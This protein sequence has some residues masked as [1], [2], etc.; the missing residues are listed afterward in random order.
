MVDGILMIITNHREYEIKNSYSTIH[1]DFCANFE[2]PNQTQ[3]NVRL[4]DKD[5]MTHAICVCM[6]YSAVRFK[7]VPWLVFGKPKIASHT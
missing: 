1:F 7:S 4:I 6:R 2:S 5:V 3:G